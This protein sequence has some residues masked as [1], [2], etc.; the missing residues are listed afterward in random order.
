[1][2]AIILN[3]GLV[4]SLTRGSAKT[5][6]KISSAVATT[7][8]IASTIKCDGRIF[9]INFASAWPGAS[10]FFQSDMRCSCYENFSGVNFHREAGVV[11]DRHVSSGPTASMCLITAATL[12]RQRSYAPYLSPIISGYFVQGNLARVERSAGLRCRQ[13]HIRTATVR[14]QLTRQHRVD[15]LISVSI[16][17]K[18]GGVITP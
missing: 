12:C 10:V 6:T 11:I 16:S 5:P 7:I 8:R 18:S 2:S 9:R 15:D 14:R 4:L 17:Q 13:R 3:R 1:M